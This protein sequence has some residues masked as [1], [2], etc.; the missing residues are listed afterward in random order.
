MK[1][2]LSGFL[3]V[4]LTSP[5]WAFS[6]ADLLQNDG[7]YM[8]GFVAG[9]V[10]AMLT[11]VDTNNPMNLEAAQKRRQCLNQGN[12]EMP[13]FYSALVSYVK[14]NPEALTAQ[15]ERSIVVVMNQICPLK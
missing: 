5:A 6:G 8:Q 15:I 7:V 9:S 10:S 2:L 13:T 12:I 4:F 3:S 14:N 11:Y 1:A